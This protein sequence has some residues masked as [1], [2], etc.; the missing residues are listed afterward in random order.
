MKKERKFV[1][2]EAEII[3]F[4][5]E[6]IVTGSGGEGDLNAGEGEDDTNIW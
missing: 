5:I 3:D 6:D 1:Y 2:P 4:S